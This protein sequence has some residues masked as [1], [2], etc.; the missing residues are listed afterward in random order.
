MKNFLI[1]RIIAI[2]TK[3]KLSAELNL[4]NGLNL[5]IGENKTGKS[6]LI[7]SIFKPL[8]GKVS[9]EDFWGSNVNEY[10]LSFEINEMSFILRFSETHEKH[11]ILY[12][13]E[14]HKLS[15][16]SSYKTVQDLYSYL[17]PLSNINFLLPQ[18]SDSSKDL[19]ITYSLILSYM[20]IDQD[21]GWEKIASSFPDTNQYKSGTKDIIKYVV[22]YLNYEYYSLTADKLKLTQEKNEFE[23][24]LNTLLDFINQLKN[25]IDKNNDRVLNSD[26]ASKILKQIENE[27]KELIGIVERIENISNK[28]Y[29]SKLK[30]HQLSKIIADYDKDLEFAQNSP[31]ELPCPYCG[32][33]YKN[34]VHNQVTIVNSRQQAENILVMEERNLTDLNA[35]NSQLNEKKTK[36]ERILNDLKKKIKGSE[37]EISIEETIKQIGKQ[38]LIKS[39]Y[40]KTESIKQEMA[41]HE[42][43]IEEKER[44][45]NKLKSRKRSKAITDKIRNINISILEKLAVPHNEIKYSNFIMSNINKFTGSTH[46]RAVLSYYIALYLYNIDNNDFLFKNL[47][48]DTPN[49][50]G[51]DDDNLEKIH[52]VIPLLNSLKGQVIICSERLTGHESSANN[53]VYLDNDSYKTLNGNNFDNHIQILKKLDKLVSSN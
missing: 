35:R 52:G 50:Q 47:I 16:I 27:E 25:E 37:A 33:I 51:Q 23:K 39:S 44:N 15:Y 2:S 3:N 19:Y 41:K 5:I 45:I 1:K 21:H 53:V 34:D 9:F 49:Q 18:R 28:A 42:V 17:S 30:T 10:I 13:N 40:Y 12:N 11:Y 20:Y 29:I 22:G 32:T 7:K 38:E 48:I 4:K 26:I 8:G 31:H 46:P 24:K 14:S 43:D 36:I 6:S